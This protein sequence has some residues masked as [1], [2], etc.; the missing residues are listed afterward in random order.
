MGLQLH[1]PCHRAA[2][3]LVHSEFPLRDRHSPK[4]RGVGA[5]GLEGALRELQGAIKLMGGEVSG[6]SK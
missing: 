3:L 6:R 5:I 4:G 2:G 1:E